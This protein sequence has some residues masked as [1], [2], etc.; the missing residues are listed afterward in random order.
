MRRS[1]PVQEFSQIADD[2]GLC[3]PD[4]DALIYELNEAGLILYKAGKYSVNQE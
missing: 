3:V 2:M 1:H 4:L